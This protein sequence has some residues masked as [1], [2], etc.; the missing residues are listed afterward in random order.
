MKDDITKLFPEE[1]YINKNEEMVAEIS[2]ENLN[3]IVDYII[4]LLKEN[5]KLME[6]YGRL[7]EDYVKKEYI[8]KAI[9]NVFDE[10]KGDDK[11]GG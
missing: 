8:I 3:K 5:N 9:E 11:N 6:A 4:N 1:F 10:T 2:L 7:T